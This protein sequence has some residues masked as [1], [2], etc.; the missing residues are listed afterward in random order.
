MHG[1][2]CTVALF[3][4]KGLIGKAWTIPRLS[5]SLKPVLSISSAAFGERLIF[6]SGFLVFAALIGR[7]GDVAMATNQ[8]LIAIESLGFILSSGFSIA[9]GALV[10][11]KLGAENPDDAEYCAWIST[12]MALLILSGVAFV[13]WFFP[14]PLLELFSEDPAVIELG[15]DCLKLAAFA[16]P[17]MA[18]T[19]TM[20]GALRGAGDTR[21]PMI[22]SFI[23]PLTLRIAACWFFAFELEMGLIG[24][25]WGTTLDW[26][27]RAVL[28]S[29]VFIRGG[30]KTIHV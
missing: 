20:G 27:L 1:I 19:D 11:Q 7:L 12:C 24:I 10:A 30:W 2:L 22:I 4:K 28:L 18:I 13:F 9:G 26:F 8:S 25:W 15:V 6:H 29:W 16:Q 17:L 14:R 5:P 23:G 21:N 3:R